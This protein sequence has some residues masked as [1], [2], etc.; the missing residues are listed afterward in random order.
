[1]LSYSQAVNILFI[2]FAAFVTVFPLE[3]NVS[4]LDIDCPGDT[5]PYHCSILSNSETIQLAWKVTFPEMVPL[6][7]SY[8]GSS[9]S[10][11][12]DMLGMNITAIVSNYIAEE[13]IESVI[14]LTILRNVS[15]NGTILE[16][17][18][19]DLD[20]VTLDVDVDSNGNRTFKISKMW[21]CIY[22][23]TILSGLLYNSNVH[24]S[25]Q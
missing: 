20:N 24:F 14:T 3:R 17:S 23:P 22:R 5:I 2:F 4:R 10:N 8:D 12:S 11:N 16:C 1:M 9:V 21:S 7:I 13:V 6:S 25:R 18:S 19:E 15:M